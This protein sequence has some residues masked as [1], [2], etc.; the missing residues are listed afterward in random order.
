MEECKLKRSPILD[1]ANMIVSFYQAAYDA[2]QKHA[3]M[4]KEDIPLLEPWENLWFTYVSGVFLSSYLKT[5]AD[6]SFLP[7]DRDRD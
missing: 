7:S 6:A 1:L 5:A 2:L 3:S 4:R